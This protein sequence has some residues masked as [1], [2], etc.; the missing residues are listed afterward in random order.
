MEGKKYE[1]LFKYLHKHSFRI[2]FPKNKLIESLLMLKTSNVSTGIVIKVLINAKKNL[3][4]CS[5][6]KQ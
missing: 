3:S 2:Y 1:I 5:E 6:L 4:L